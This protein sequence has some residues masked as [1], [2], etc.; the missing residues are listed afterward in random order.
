MK[1]AAVFAFNKAVKSAKTGCRLLDFQSEITAAVV[2]NAKAARKV[3]QKT[4]YAAKEFVDTAALAFK[5][6]PMKAV[7]CTF[8]TAFAI[9]AVTGWLAR[10]K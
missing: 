6:N 2:K 3:M 9:G 5:R 4:Q 1:N 8:G 10:K 7:C